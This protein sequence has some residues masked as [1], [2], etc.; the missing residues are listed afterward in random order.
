VSARRPNILLIQSDQHRY[1]CLG[2]EATA[3]LEAT[4][5]A[6]R[7][8]L[9]RTPYLDRLAA[10]G[11]SFARAYCP[12]PVCVPARV[13]LI[14]GAWPSRHGVIA[15][16]GTEAPYPSRERTP[17]GRGSHAQEVL[18][19]YT[20]AL[21]DGGYALAHVGKW[22]VHPEK[23]PPAYGYDVHIPSSD[24]AAWRARRGLPPRPRHGGWF[25]ELDPGAGPQDTRLAWG[26]D[27]IIERLE[28]YAGRGAPFYVQWDTDE[29][30][31]PWVLPEPY[32]S[33]YPPGEIPPWPSFPDPL[34]GKPYIQAQQRRTWGID[35]WT[36]DEWAPVVARYLGEI[37]LLDAQ[38]GRVLEALARL[39][40]AED[41]VVVY[42][43]DHG[44]LCGGH[45]MIDKH[46]VMYEDVVH[47]PLIVRWPGV[48][49][50]GVRCPAFVC[51]ALDLALTFCQAA[52]APVPETFQGQSLLPLLAGEEASGRSDIYS[53]Y[54][55]NQFGLYSQR[56]V[57]DARWKYVWNAT[58]E[59]ELYDLCADPGELH[60]LAAAPS[61]GDEL[62]RLR[63]RLV[64]WMEETGDRL[65]NGWTR[66][67]LLE[68]R[69]V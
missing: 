16:W 46:Y 2:S 7:H 67:Q 24:Y 47:V 5:A 35:D 45:G 34:A 64:A 58:A 68:G 40:L 69:K 21:K 59:D 10:E 3:A 13:S 56:M 23:G 15:N 57:R 33:M 51:G 9:V 25:G 22:Q 66:A 30:H 60:N 61:Y 11:M 41:T 42:T 27:R 55:G 20:Q 63:H 65:L 31:L 52:G 18:P 53:V 1:D 39:G 4:A 54:H 38:V 43:A 37:S 62:R 49:A 44:G 50:P 12:I 28:A 48:A 17:G 14:H 29:P 26:A 32:Y 6:S 19:T 8:P 36:W